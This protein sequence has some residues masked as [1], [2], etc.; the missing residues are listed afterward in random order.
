MQNEEGAIALIA[1]LR[2]LLLQ[3]VHILLK[4]FAA[5][6]DLGLKQCL[7]LNAATNIEND[8]DGQK[9]TSHCGKDLVFAEPESRHA[10]AKV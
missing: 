9:M 2:D 6:M 10:W 1:L 4:R 5:D 7:G 8:V 3:R